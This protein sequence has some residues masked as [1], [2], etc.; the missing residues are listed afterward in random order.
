MSPYQYLFKY[1]I[2]GDTGVGKSCLLLQFTDK[3]FRTDHDLTIGVEF[4]ARLIQIDGRQI[5]LQIWDTAGQESF[6]SI[7]RS[8]YRG[9]AGALLVYDISRRD[10]FVHLSRWLEEVR[11]NSNPYMTIILVG[12]KSDLERREVT[13]QEVS[14][15]AGTVAVVGAG[16]G[17]DFARQNNLIFL[18]TSAKTAQNVEEA[19]ILTARKIYENIQAGIYDLSSDAHG[20]KCG[21]VVTQRP[22]RLG[23]DSLAAVAAADFAAAAV[24]AAAVAACAGGVMGGGVALAAV[25]EV[26]QQQH[27]QHQQRLQQQHHMEQRQHLQR[28]SN[29]NR[30]GAAAPTGQQQQQLLLQLQALGHSAREASRRRVSIG[31]DNEPARHIRGPLQRGPQWVPR[32]GLP[33]KGPTSCFA[34]MTFTG[35]PCGPPPGAPPGAPFRALVGL[36]PG[37]PPTVGAPVN[38]QTD[39]EWEVG[40]PGSPPVVALESASCSGS[41]KAVEISSC[42]SLLF[43]AV[44]NTIRVYSLLQG[45]PAEKGPPE[46]PPVEEGCSPSPQG[47]PLAAVYFSPSEHVLGLTERRGLL[48][49]YGTTCLTVY[50]L[51]WQGPPGCPTKGQS[52]IRGGPVGALKYPLQDGE[53]PQGHLAL[54]QIFMKRD[55]RRVLT[56]EFLFLGHPSSQAEAA[57]VAAGVAAA[58]VQPEA[59]K[60]LGNCCLEAASTSAA[61]AAATRGCSLGAYLLVLFSDGLLR[62]F[63]ATTGAVLLQLRCSKEYLQLQ[64]A[65]A[66]ET[67]LPAPADVP[68]RCCCSSTSSCCCT[69]SSTSNSSSTCCK[70]RQQQLQLLLAGGTAF[71]EIFVWLLKIDAWELL[72][73]RKETAE[74][75]VAAAATCAAAAAAT[76]LVLVQRL[77]GHRGGIFSLAFAE[78]GALLASA[79][80]DREVRL[81]LR[82]PNAAAAAAAATAAAAASTAA[83]EASAAGHPSPTAAAVAAAVRM[84]LP[85]LSSMPAAIEGTAVGPPTGGPPTE[86]T[87]NSAVALHQGPHILISY[88]CVSV[89]RGHRS[90]IWA[91]SFLD[92]MPAFN[93]QQQQ[94]QQQLLLQQQLLEQQLEHQQQQQQPA[95]SSSTIN[96]DSLLLHACCCSLLLL[97]GGED[98]TVRVWSLKGPCLYTLEAHRGGGV[99]SLAA[100]RF[101]FS[102]AFPFFVSGGEDGSSKIWPL[103]ALQSLRGALVQHATSSTKHLLQMLQPLQAQHMQAAAAAAA[104]LTP[105]AAAAEDV[106]GPGPM[107]KTLSLQQ[108]LAQPQQQQLPSLTHDGLQQQQLQQQVQQKQKRRQQRQEQQK[109]K[110]KQETIQAKR[111]DQGDVNSTGLKSWMWSCRVV[112]AAEAATA[113]AATTTETE[114]EEKTATAAAFATKET[115]ALD[116]A[117]LEAPS[118]DAAQG[119]LAAAAATAATTA[120]TA[121]ATAEEICKG[122][123]GWLG[124]SSKDFIREVFLCCCEETEGDTLIVSTN[125]GH[126]Y[127][128]AHLPAATAVEGSVTTATTAAA[129]AAATPFRWLLLCCVSSPITATGVADN[130]LCLGGADG[131]IRL[132]LLR[133][134]RSLIGGL[135]RQQQQLQKPL[136]QHQ[137]RWGLLQ[138]ADV[139]VVKAFGG[140]RVA[141]GFLHSLGPLSAPSAAAV[142]AAA[143]SS[144]MLLPLARSSNSSS[145]I[146]AD[147]QQTTALP[148]TAGLVVAGDHTGSVNFY[149]WRQQQQYAGS[150]VAASAAHAAADAALSTA[151][152]SSSVAGSSLQLQMLANVCLPRYRKGP[153][154]VVAG[155][156]SSATNRIMSSIGMLSVCSK[157]ES[158][159]SAVMSVVYLLGDEHGTLHAVLLQVTA[160]AEAT[161][162]ETEAVNQQQQQHQQHQQSLQPCWNWASCRAVVQQPL[163]ELFPRRRVCALSCCRG[164]TFC[165]GGDGRILILQVSLSRSNN[166]GSSS[167]SGLWVHQEVIIQQLHAVRVS[168]ISNFVCLLPQ[169]PLVGAGGPWQGDSGAALLQH[170]MQQQQQQDDGFV[171]LQQHVAVGVRGSELFAFSFTQGA[172]LLQLPCG[173]S[174]RSFAAATRQGETVSFAFSRGHCVC[175]YTSNK[176][177]TSSSWNDARLQQQDDEEMLLLPQQQLQRRC[178]SFNPNYPGDDIHAVSF[179]SPSVICAA[180]EDNTLSLILWQHSPAATAAAAATGNHKLTDSL[181]VLSIT[182]RHRAA[183]RALALLQQWTPQQQ[184]RQQQQQQKQKQLYS[185]PRL[186]ASAGAAQTLNLF[187]LSPAA[188]AAYEM[189]TATATAAASAGSAAA[190]AAAP[191]TSTASVADPATVTLVHLQQLCLEDRTAKGPSANARFNTACGFVCTSYQ[192][193]QQQ[194]QVQA[195]D[196]YVLVGVS[197]ARLLLIRFRISTGFVEAGAGAVTTSPAAAV[198]AMAY[199]DSETFRAEGRPTIISSLKLPAVPFCCQLIRVPSGSPSTVATATEAAEAAVVPEKAAVGGRDKGLIVMGL[200]DGSVAFAELQLQQQQ[201]QQREG[202]PAVLPVGALS[203]HQRAITSVCVKLLQQQ[204]TATAAAATDASEVEA[205]RLLVCTAGDDDAIAVQVLSLIS[206]V[207]PP[208]A[209]TAAATASTAAAAAPGGSSSRWRMQ[210]VSRVLHPNAHSSSVRSLSLCW[211]ILFSVGWDRWLQAWK[212]CRSSSNSNNTNNNNNNNNNNRGSSSCLS[213]TG[214]ACML[215]KASSS[216]GL[217]GCCCRPPLCCLDTPGTAIAADS[218]TAAQQDALRLDEQLAVLWRRCG[219]PVQQQ[220]QE[221]HRGGQAE[222]ETFMLQRLAAAK[223]GVA[224]AASLAAVPLLSG[225]G[226]QGPQGFTVRLCCAG[227]SGG[228][229]VFELHTTATPKAIQT[230]K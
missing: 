17:Q 165:C 24:V 92:L 189:T 70:G 98:S 214:R 227:A 26:R 216:G 219:P 109:Q 105:A 88:K 229:E 44:A 96:L 52:E 143:A 162:A 21:P 168:Q 228:I 183:V 169:G 68:D 128:V 164:F 50:E 99:R 185:L 10:T 108:E 75:P 175:L 72:R 167:T 192:Q 144:N 115:E 42:G 8:Y 14:D 79:S 145:S 221:E 140:V 171:L 207:A 194:Q 62:I 23:K 39:I 133:P 46:G 111:T 122:A 32:A 148:A 206:T 107:K 137:G 220:Q 110:Q 179:L 213:S 188:P 205:L 83:A 193:Q 197:T 1:I 142:A 176:S 37:S 181:R 71:S 45:V 34:L 82:K 40:A 113:A 131:C 31:F 60:R 35:A 53:R 16:G 25:D 55:I 152:V 195:Y 74:K 2:I 184:Q 7:T 6:R 63:H 230:K 27:L 154:A 19:F 102:A 153:R 199:G 3:R 65:A 43:V 141:S 95:L 225:V 127:L 11:Q 218:L 22:T 89:F 36:E 191:D 161:P 226:P 173:D 166:N 136:Y 196:A 114:G 120:T 132:C 9:A 54:Q 223:T 211:P 41:V 15:A 18:E 118:G 33:L 172:P 200:T 174:K 124:G 86:G 163:K 29:D 215:C 97:S 5:K 77:E 47:P 155:G 139:A 147:V 58:D 117:D 121:T 125:Y 182:T 187:Q 112:E 126:V 222:T 208:P 73:V 157:K 101:T 170:L 210:F 61:P 151:A 12:N 178:I 116:I 160:A 78:G 48:T 49:A 30:A 90:R 76:S 190:G 135:R 224:E 91:V 80:E 201:Q 100:S 130:C 66:T 202:N 138:A 159:A 81:W 198:A 94:Q 67:L 106:D 204:S 149:S 13:F 212:I 56:A 59:T 158:K 123:C 150:P 119:T 186:L 87:L 180:A 57:A 38:L 28:R 84:L 177:S 134:L 203:T 209:A 64:A 85:A 129:A 104:K 146:W 20:I 103:E 93:L 4:G 217:I 69:C 156:S 51:R